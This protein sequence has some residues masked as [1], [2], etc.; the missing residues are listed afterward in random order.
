MGLLVNGQWQDKWYD[1]DNNQGEFKREAA[2]LRNWVSEDGSAGLSGDAGFKAEKDRYHLYVSLACPWAHRTLIFRHLKG[3]EDYISVSVVSPDMLEHGWTFDKDNHSTG[4]ALFDSEFMHQIYTR[5]KADYSGRVT[6][7]V[8]WDKKTQ[9]IVSNESAEIIRMFNS[10]F[11][12]LTGN[13]RDFYPQSLRS[14]IDE[15]NE[16]VYHNINNG[17]YRAGFAT[18]QEAYT[19]AFDNLFAALDKIEQRLTAN[20][21][22]VGDTLTEADWRLFTTLIRF[23][24]VY[25]GHFKCNLRTIESY[26]AISNY[27]RELYQVEGVSKTVDFYHIK[28]HY[29]FSHTMINPTQVVPKGPDIDYA[30]PHNRG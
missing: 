1:T 2:Q 21:Y 12:A 17:V 7:P 26:P 30:R 19:E 9:R 27:L 6:V 3:L 10:A 25:V 22:L 4:D 13:E 24:S 5:N 28:R 14:E 16:F 11:N 23:D 18:T 20:R 15:V 29:Y 8:L